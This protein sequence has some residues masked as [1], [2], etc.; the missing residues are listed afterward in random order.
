MR[1]HQIAFIFLCLAV[2]ESETRFGWMLL[3]V[4]FSFTFGFGGSIKFLLAF[5]DSPSHHALRLRPAVRADA[6]A[7]QLAKELVRVR[8]RD[9]IFWIIC[10]VPAAAHQRRAH[11]LLPPISCQK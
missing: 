10:L 2:A 5:C 6:E 3:L 4:L 1:I 8:E 11:V 9:G 7:A